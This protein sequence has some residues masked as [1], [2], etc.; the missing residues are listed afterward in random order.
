[1]SEIK[2]VNQER[3]Q[4]KVFQTEFSKEHRKMMTNAC[5]DFISMDLRP[6]NALYGDGMNALLRTY[7]IV[8][9]HYGRSMTN[10]KDMLP[11]NSTVSRNIVMRSESV[12][13]S[14]KK[15]LPR[16]FQN[17]GAISADIW[18]DHHNKV[19]YLGVLVHYMDTQGRLY[20]RLIS[21]K[22]LDTEES[23][24]G[25]YIKDVLF[26]ELKFYDIDLDK[27]NV[28]FVTDR[29]SNM[30]KSLEFYQRNSCA[31]HFVN[32]V[33]N[34]ILKYGRPAEILVACRNIVTKVHQL[35]KNTLFEPRLQSFCS[36]RWNSAYTMFNSVFEN[37]GQIIDLFEESR[38]RSVLADTTAEE[39]EQLKSFLSVFREVNT[40]LQ[41]TSVPSIHLV[42]LLY[43]KLEK[44]FLTCENDSEIVHTAKE[45][46]RTYFAT[47]LINKKM[48]TTYHK[49]GV[50]L[51]PTGKGMNQMT[52]QDKADI[53]FEVS[54][55]VRSGQP[56]KNPKNMQ[57]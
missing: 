1:M 4:P 25:K 55:S 43:A 49:L 50:F 39:I 36:T 26:A 9:N 38:C 20:N 53:Q 3:S 17:G 5:I 24:T 31:A 47:T 14:L 13:E 32:N 34:E 56:E 48:V 23:H 7:A 28:V 51:H 15:I 54:Y 11:S 16:Y 57:N 30:I 41:Q 45:N 27:S 2:A 18:T 19:S 46:G 22:P 42:C 10:A 29:G 21:N 6:V 35:G 37:W 12:Q 44:Q 8:A 33:V 40:R 52:N